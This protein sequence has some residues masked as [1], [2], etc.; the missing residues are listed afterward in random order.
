MPFL[1]H[2]EHNI[3]TKDPKTQAKMRIENLVH[4][5]VLMSACIVSIIVFSPVLVGQK[6]VSFFKTQNNES[7]VDNGVKPTKI[8]KTV[9]WQKEKLVLDPAKLL[10]SSVCK[11]RGIT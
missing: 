3:R 6:V 4:F 11:K 8:K 5:I 2:S 10:N 1:F 7:E 9:Q